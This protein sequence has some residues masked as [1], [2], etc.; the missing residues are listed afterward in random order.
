M[1]SLSNVEALLR[2]DF[3]AEANSG[4]AGLQRIPCTAIVKL[5]DYLEPLDREERDR[6]LDVLARMGAMKFFPPQQIAIEY[7]SL[8][9]TNSAFV[10]CWSATH[11]EPTAAGLRYQS[12]KMAKM[13]LGDA[14]SRA[15]MLKYRAELPS[16]PR[17]DPPESL[18]PRDD[19]GAVEAA[20]APLLRKLASAA[21]KQH[22]AAGSNKLAGG[23][24]EYLGQIGDWKVSVRIDFGAISAQLRYVVSVL[25]PRNS[26]S[27]R[28]L[29]YEDLWFPNAGWDYLTEENAQR[30][31]DLLVEQ[32]QYLVN[33]S[34]RIVA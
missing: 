26:I 5:L 30:S 16:H 29:S 28:R 11:S 20:K 14:E 7:E 34:A 15:E 27:V 32:I 3:D 33:L 1:D 18:V 21:L 9:S 25:N 19:L 8:R 17:D 4:F 10:K 2:T 12:V 22:F 13:M 24:T 6:L 23:E 31:I